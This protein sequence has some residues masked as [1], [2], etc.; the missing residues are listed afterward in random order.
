VRN[1]FA[2]LLAVAESVFAVIHCRLFLL[3]AA[4]LL[5]AVSDAIVLRFVFGI[6]DF[7]LMQRRRKTPCY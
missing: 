5:E 6:R 3:F 4:D 7:K 1:R 2:V